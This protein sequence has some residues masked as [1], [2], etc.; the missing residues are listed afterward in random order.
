[1]FETL[2]AWRWHAW[3]LAFTASFAAPFSVADQVPSAVR[4][5]VLVHGA[6]ADGSS[7][8]PVIDI[9][10]RQG[11]HVTAVQNPLTSLADDAAATRRV[12]ERQNEDVILVGHSWGGV[13]VTEVGQAAHV[14]GLVYLSALVPDIGESAAGMLS[15]LGAPIQ[16]MA[17][18]KDGLVWLDDPVAYRRMM[19]G[20]VSEPQARRLAAT[21]QPIAV[22]AFS[23]KV[24]AAPWRTRPSW[25]L[26]TENDKALPPG[27][28]HALA[29]HI[30]AT[31]V[32]LKSSHLSWMS[33]PHAV[34]SLIEQ[35][36]QAA[37][38]SLR[39]AP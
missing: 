3:A 20:D 34:A 38:R 26:V 32:T 30:G 35:A 15:R 36:A 21:Q 31:T 28:Q 4:H 7:W 8:S 10:L 33:Q 23:D 27:V 37:E 25:Y 17:P 2:R 19:A 13:V 22:R 29:Q 16:G 39:T 12:L 14:K 6:F 1:M 5:I 24:T 9:L 18:D 11:Y